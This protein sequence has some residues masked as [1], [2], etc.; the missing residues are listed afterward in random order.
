M[1]KKKIKCAALRDKDGNIFWGRYHGEIFL[2]KPIGV[3]RK[4]EQ[5]FL[6]TEGRFVDRK[7]ALK[8]ATEQDQ[9]IKKSSPF[10][11]L[12]SSDFK[13]LLSDKELYDFLKR[14]LKL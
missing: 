5:G 3:L 2:Q 7:E 11:Q 10:E 6:T 4:A 9:I 12:D 13:H 1:D 14:K 8:I